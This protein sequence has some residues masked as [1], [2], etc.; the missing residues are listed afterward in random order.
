MKKKKSNNKTRD[1]REEPARTAA[2]AQ[3]RLSAAQKKQKQVFLISP[4]VQNGAYEHEGRKVIK[5][6][7]FLLVSELAVGVPRG[8]GGKRVTKCWLRFSE[9][10]H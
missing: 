6:K 9:S 5:Q 1:G 4:P 3:T 7:D 2:D 10:G 8:G